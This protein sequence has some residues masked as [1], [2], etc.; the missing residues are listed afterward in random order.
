[1]TSSTTTRHWLETQIMSSVAVVTITTV[2]VVTNHFK[3]VAAR[4]QILC[5]HKKRQVSNL[6]AQFTQSE[7]HSSTIM[8]TFP[9]CQYTRTWSHTLAI[10]SQN[11]SARLFSKSMASF[12]EIFLPRV[13]SRGKCCPAAFCLFTIRSS[14]AL[15]PVG[16]ALWSQHVHFA[17]TYTQV[18]C[19]EK[20]QA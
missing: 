14:W 12:T 5:A 1:M 20:Q 2:C 18:R 19:R 15:S 17:C 6:Q 10:S 9:R 3:R 11:H 7:L 8:H 16:Q 4:H 13:Q